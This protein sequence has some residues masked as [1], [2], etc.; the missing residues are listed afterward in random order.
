MGRP[1]TRIGGH[2]LLVF[3]TQEY[4]SLLLFRLVSHMFLNERTQGGGRLATL[5]IPL[6]IQEGPTQ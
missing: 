5:F 4:G 6:P 1:T 2:L 3:L